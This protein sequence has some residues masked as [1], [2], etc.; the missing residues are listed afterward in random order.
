[1][2]RCRSPSGNPINL[3]TLK[4]FSSQRLSLTPQ[5]L[6][7]DDAAPEGHGGCPGRL[8]GWLPGQR[9]SRLTQEGKKIARS[10][11]LPELKIHPSF[12]ALID[13]LRQTLLGVSLPRT[14]LR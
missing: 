8:I 12:G 1:M 2:V 4:D 9:T 13:F 14:G 3:V 11:L 10:L 6:L 5:E 7:Y